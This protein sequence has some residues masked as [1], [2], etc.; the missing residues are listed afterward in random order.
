MQGTDYILLRLRVQDLFRL[1]CSEDELQRCVDHWYF[2][3]TDNPEYD[4]ETYEPDEVPLLLEYEQR[5]RDTGNAFLN[6]A[7]EVLQVP[8]Q[9][10]EALAGRRRKAK[11]VGD[12]LQLDPDQAVP[13][14][15]SNEECVDRFRDAYI[16]QTR[17]RKEAE[18]RLNLNLNAGHGKGAE[19]DGDVMSAQDH[20]LSMPAWAYSEKEG[21][22]ESLSE[23]IGRDNV[24]SIHHENETNS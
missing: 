4:F 19:G 22:E 1:L 2:E 17:L 20:M 3:F 12:W 7:V 18:A 16:E 14:P 23:F 24:Q 8:T 11:Q 9:Y 21:G 15:Q 5:L 10:T 13:G 6:F